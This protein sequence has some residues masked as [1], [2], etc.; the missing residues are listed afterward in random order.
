VGDPASNIR[1]VVF[2]KVV[3]RHYS[4]EVSELIIFWCEISSG[5][6]TPNIIKIGSFFAEL[7]KI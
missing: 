4:G 2:H 1:F 6:C 7:F 3:Q 5:F